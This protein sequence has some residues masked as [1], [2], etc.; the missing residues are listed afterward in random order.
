MGCID[1][2]FQTVHRCCFSSAVKMSSS[3]QFQQNAHTHIQTYCLNCCSNVLSQYIF[4]YVYLWNIAQF[5]R[6][7]L[8]WIH[9]IISNDGSQQYN[10][11]QRNQNYYYLCNE[12]VKMLFG[13]GFSTFFGVSKRVKIYIYNIYAL[14]ILHTMCSFGITISHSKHT[15]KKKK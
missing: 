9:F 4:I 14:F 11:I 15:T 3:I 12:I 7:M 6:L 5:K 8:M 2:I 13:I 1:F 10:K